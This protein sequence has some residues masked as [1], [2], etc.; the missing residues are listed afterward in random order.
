MVCFYPPDLKDKFV[1]WLG[2]RCLYL[3]QRGSDLGQRMKNSFTSAFNSHFNPVILIG[4]DIPDLPGAFIK[5]A[6]LALKTHEVVIGPSFDGGYYLI[7]FG[8][9]AFLPGAFD[10][11]NWGTQTVFHDTLTVLQ[12]AVYNI[13]LLP[14][15]GDVDTYAHL[16]HLIERNQNTAFRYSKTISYLSKI[17]GYMGEDVS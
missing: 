10:E 11:I 1:E 8:N 12:S 3:P 16:K 2:I 14:K 6:L 15:W 13:H 7:G 17:A 9:N 5:K 4:S